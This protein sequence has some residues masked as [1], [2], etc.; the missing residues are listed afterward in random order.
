M[1]SFGAIWGLLN[2]GFSPPK[3]LGSFWFGLLRT[4]QKGVREN[5]KHAYG[6]YTARLGYILLLF[7]FS[8]F[9]GGTNIPVH[10]FS[11]CLYTSYG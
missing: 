11:V 2:I 4:N 1:S 7:C 10:D 5:E 3:W 9:C 8:F 6:G